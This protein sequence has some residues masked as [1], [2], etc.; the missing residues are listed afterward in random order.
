MNPVNL[1]FQETLRDDNDPKSPYQLKCYRSSPV[2]YFDNNGVVLQST[3]EIWEF[4]SSRK[5]DSVGGYEIR[6]SNGK[7]SQAVGE[8]TDL[9]RAK[10]EL[11][12]FVNSMREKGHSAPKWIYN[13]NKGKNQMYYSFK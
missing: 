13:Q 1:T 11:Q 5:Q 3:P 6:F 10:Q 2:K 4:Y 9:K 12:N 7:V 8:F